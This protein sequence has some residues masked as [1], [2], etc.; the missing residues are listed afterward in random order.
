MSD[1]SQARRCPVCQSEVEPSTIAAALGGD[2]AAVDGPRR[3]LRRGSGQPDAA[4]PGYGPTQFGADVCPQAI[5]DT[6]P[7]GHGL[8][9]WVLVDSTEDECI[10]KYDGGIS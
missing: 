2:R 6:D 7:E 1:E 9:V 4:G 8:G 3:S 5:I 10:Y